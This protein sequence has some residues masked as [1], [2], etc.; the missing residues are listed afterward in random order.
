MHSLALLAALAAVPAA[1]LASAPLVPIP[2]FTAEQRD[3]FRRQGLTP[4]SGPL[5]LGEPGDRRERALPV[6]VT[7]RFARL[8][9]GPSPRVALV[10]WLRGRWSWVP[11]R[12]P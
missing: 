6:E 8:P 10:R 2:A 3:A 1:A 9:D 4:L 12:E 7:A 11:A 5:R